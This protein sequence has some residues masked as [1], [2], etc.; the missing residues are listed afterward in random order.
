[1]TESGIVTSTISD[2]SA[3]TLHLQS[4]EYVQRGPGFWKINNSLLSDERFI[5]DLSSK[6]PEFKTKHD[7]LDNKGLYWDMI[8]MEV[9][10]FCVQYKKRKNRE[11]QNT[12]KHLKQ[13]IDQLINKLKTDRTKDKISKLYRLRAEYNA[14]AEYRTKG[15]I[16]RR[17]IRWHENGERNTKYFLNME[18]KTTC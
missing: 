8:K 15:A 5:W 10:G 6:I 3:I 13:E 9:R 12:E 16:V 2:H 18:K 4:K 14:I 17:R 1:M 11:C 7:Y